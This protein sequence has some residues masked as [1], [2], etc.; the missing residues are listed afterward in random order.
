MLAACGGGGSTA[1]PA[2]P[3]SAKGTLGHFSLR[4]PDGRIRTYYL[5]VP[6]VHPAR[7]QLMIALHGALDT[8]ADL[9][10]ETDF[11]HVG[12]QRGMLVAYPQ[13]YDDTWN[14][15]A[16]HTPAERAGINDV[17]FIKLM[18]AQIEARYPVNTEKI[19]ASGF[20]NGALMVELLGCRLAGTIAL[21]APVAG[22]LPVSVSPTCTPSQPVGVLAVHGT[23]DAA[24][25]FN[26]GPF[27]GVGGGTTV[28]SEPASVARWAKL[29]GCARDRRTTHDDNRVITTYKNGC[30]SGVLV[31]LIAI[32]G[33]GH[34]NPTDIGI[35]VADAL[36][37][38]R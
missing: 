28:L 1:A 25:P 12:E 7:M 6:A 34:V 37:A 17:E 38:S 13:G 11:A 4:T 15:G 9:V 26:G 21:I 24:I 35:L 18:I 22:Q 2:A 19:A 31:R 23:A 33:G 36:G 30:R 20:S 14:E 16:G 5:L 29:D 8:A 32:T 10:G 27:D 3:P